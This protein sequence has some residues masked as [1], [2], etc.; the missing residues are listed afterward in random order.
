M[1]KSF[2][3]TIFWILGISFLAIRFPI[4]AII[5]SI[6]SAFTSGLI[7]WWILNNDEVKEFENDEI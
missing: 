7:I 3:I 2:I 1:M 4:L 6:G 5:I